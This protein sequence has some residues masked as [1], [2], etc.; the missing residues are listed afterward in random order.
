MVVALVSVG[1]MI[2]SNGGSTV[3]DVE[4]AAALGQGG[5]LQQLLAS[6][7][8]GTLESLVHRGHVSIE[9]VQALMN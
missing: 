6:L 2:E 4:T 5:A 3:L 8:A 1:W 7:P 9:H